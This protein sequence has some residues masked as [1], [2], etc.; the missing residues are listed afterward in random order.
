V[1]SVLI[2]FPLVFGWVHFRSAPDDQMTYVTYVFGF[3]LA[4]FPLAT[5][6]SWTVFHGLDIAAVLVLGGVGMSLWRR[7]RDPGAR[8]VQDFSRDIFPLVLLFAIAVTGLALTVSATW[9]RGGSYQFL[10]LI[11]AVVVVLA[12][13]YLGFGKFFH[14][15]Q[16]PAQLGV[17]LYREAGERGPGADCASCGQ[18]FASRM[19]VEDLAAVLEELGF[20][21]RT[22]RGATWQHV[23]PAC[24]R[25]ALARAQLRL[26]EHA[27]G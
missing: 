9:L 27:R 24:K 4:S 1:L 13:V 8:A 5:L 2:T 7:M 3:P 22:E 26:Q 14:I 15:F 20:D 17:Q 6:V 19:H 23:C 16:R 18:R 10:A 12:L 21:Y 11:H 25:K